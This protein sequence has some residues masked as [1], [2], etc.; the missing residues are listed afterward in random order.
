MSDFLLAW[1][2]DMED[3]LGRSP[4]AKDGRLVDG[5]RAEIVIAMALVELCTAVREN[6]AAILADKGV[7]DPPP[8]VDPPGPVKK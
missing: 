2:A 7:T 6:T 5:M 8:A 3:Y 1:R 4:A